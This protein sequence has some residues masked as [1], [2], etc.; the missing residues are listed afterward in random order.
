MPRATQAVGYNAAQQMKRQN[1]RIIHS[2][3]VSY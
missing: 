1:L 3:N 2:A